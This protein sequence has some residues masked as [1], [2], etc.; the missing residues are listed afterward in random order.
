MTDVA[1][2]PR[3]EPKRDRWGR[4]LIGGKPYTRVTTFAAS[5]DDRWN[6]EQWKCRMVVTGAISRADLF[7]QAAANIDDK[8]KLNRICDD[9]I[10]AAKGNAGANLGTALHAFTEQI[11]LGLTPTVPAPWDADLAAYTTAL[12]VNG[13]HINPAFVERIVVH[14]G[15]GIAGTFDR[16]PTVD[17]WALPVIA[18]LKTG[19]LDHASAFG[20][21]AVQLACYANADELYDPA[22]DTTS[23]MPEIDKQRAL[24]IHLPA[25]RATCT[26]YIVDIAAGWEAAQL[27][28]AVR[29]W[30]KRKDLSAPFAVVNAASAADRL[31][32]L[33][34]RA[35]SLRDTHPD[36][37]NEFAQWWPA[38][39]PTFKQ[40]G[41]TAEH[42]ELIALH[43]SAIEAKHVVPFGDGDPDQKRIDEATV[44]ALVARL[45]ALPEDIF[46]AV[47]TTAR[48]M[49]IPNVESHRFKVAHLT[50][51]EPLIV[52]AEQAAAARTSTDVQDTNKEGAAA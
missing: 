9:L 6:L 19:N 30:R 5:I 14:H 23:P 32:W 45:K 16:L 10:E 44:A 29:E 17:G 24:V 20:A 26:L 28:G 4:Y 33:K 15:L 47:R 40:G 22:T 38:G 42:V 1:V 49:G 18:D 52:D 3:P 25:G 34:Q 35:L 8:Q 2:Q 27:C 51:I 11:D 36:A 37:F 48:S 50:E 41:H 13:I 12:Q 21:I 7:A 39:V 31:D 43:L 46:E